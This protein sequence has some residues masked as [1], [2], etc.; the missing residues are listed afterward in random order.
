MN[1]REA[2]GGA[3]EERSLS[4]VREDKEEEQ[5]RAGLQA[6]INECDA[7][8]APPRL[9][10]L[11]RD[12]ACS[13]LLRTAL[14]LQQQQRPQSAEERPPPA[15]S[16][17]QTC[18][19]DLQQLKRLPDE[20]KLHLLQH[21][22]GT[23]ATDASAAA[24]LRGLLLKGPG[25]LLLSSSSEKWGE[26][27]SED[28]ESKEA[29][30]L[31][32]GRCVWKLDDA[33][34]ALLVEAEERP[35]LRY[36]RLDNCNGL[37]E[38]ALKQGLFSCRQVCS[39]LTSLHFFWCGSLTDSVLQTIGRQMGSQLQEVTIHGCSNVT[40]LGVGFL[41][42]QCSA[43][44]SLKTSAAD[45]A[46]LVRLASSSD[47]GR[48]KL[49]VLD[50]EGSSNVS[51]KGL[52]ALASSLFPS[53]VS[54][55][56]QGCKGITDAG[57]KRLGG[58]S[59]FPRLQHLNLSRCD[60]ITSDGIRRALSNKPGRTR[61]W[62]EEEDEEETKEKEEVHNNKKGVGANLVSLMLDDCPAV[63]ETL[64]EV[65]QGPTF[66]PKLKSLSVVRCP[67]LSPAVV[68]RWRAVHRPNVHCITASG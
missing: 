63:D 49:R 15:H 48:S 43:L 10:E 61:R 62:L 59:S 35:P 23:Y 40:K 21:L 53:L 3:R 11:A 6:L 24:P 2:R 25:S 45:D 50:L 66:C 22:R 58:C 30:H 65:L 36:L 26:A 18:T 19:L 38:R 31:D 51:D 60:P 52:R 54:L 14:L 57:L 42:G 29:L 68:E 5:Q 16:P 67:R 7:G 47:G 8:G 17:S 20:L 28:G 9:V 64:L 37:S 27:E 55:C 39:A 46:I 12:R 1:G 34:L 32:D 44:Q 56:L 13:F 4:A 41:I 33:S